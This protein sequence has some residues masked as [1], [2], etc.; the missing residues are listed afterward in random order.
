MRN[1]F[2]AG[3]LV[4]AMVAVSVGCGSD[5]SDQATPTGA[6]TMTGTAQA[7]VAEDAVF[8]ALERDSD[9][10]RRRCI[11]QALPC[12]RMVSDMCGHQRG[13]HVQR[14]GI[15]MVCGGEPLQCARFDKPVTCEAQG[16]CAWYP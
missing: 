2:H 14:I 12:A 7:D 8:A 6:P 10:H 4:L 5:R 11:G 3:G 1:L 15:R 16:G 9:P 13:C